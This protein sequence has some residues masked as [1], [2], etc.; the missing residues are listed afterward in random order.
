MLMTT[1]PGRLPGGVAMTAARLRPVRLGDNG[2]V[3][4]EQR[5]RTTLGAGPRDMIISMLV[6]LPLV[7]IVALLSRGCA[8]TPG[9]PTVD[10]SKLPVVV[11]HPVFVEAARRL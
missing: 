7:G 11:V 8:F 4:D 9:G 10:A 5:P 6:M 2:W 3:K 1:D